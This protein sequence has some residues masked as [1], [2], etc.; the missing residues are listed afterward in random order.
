MPFSPQHNRAETYT[1]SSS[2]QGDIITQFFKSNI[3]QITMIV[4]MT[5]LYT[6]EYLA[7]MKLFRVFPY[8]SE[9]TFS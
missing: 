1:Q 5:F 8:P 4:I 2:I 3:L 9:P 6:V 7:G